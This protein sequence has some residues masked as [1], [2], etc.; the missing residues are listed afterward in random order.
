MFMALR[1]RGPGN[2]NRNERLA[3]FHEDEVSRYPRS[4]VFEYGNFLTG[5]KV[6]WPA[7]DIEGFLER[8]RA[9]VVRSW[10]GWHPGLRPLTIHDQGRSGEA[11]R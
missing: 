8:L 10:A 2:A 1:N 6:R 9:S 4:L 11:E 7:T 5:V 3:L